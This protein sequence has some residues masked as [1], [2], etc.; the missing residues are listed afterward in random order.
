MT[1]W[2]DIADKDIQAVVALWNRCKLTR[3]WNDPVTD[4]GY[5]RRGPASAVLVRE[6]RG[7][8]VAAV[9]VG[10]DGHR[11]AIYYA[12]V[13]PDLRRIGLGREMLA[14]AESWLAERGC[15]KINIM[16][17]DDNPDA[18]GFWEKMGY[19]RNAVVS[20]GKNIRR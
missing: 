5:A 12:G 15:W 13:D 14:A 4:I 18:L 1:P 6:E 19:G 9:M 10:H 20:L 7:R 16:V 8:I 17:R 11:G 3:A 2:R